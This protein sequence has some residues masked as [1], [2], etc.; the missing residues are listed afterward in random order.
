M[1]VKRSGDRSVIVILREEV[2]TKREFE[3]KTRENMLGESYWSIVEDKVKVVEG[4]KW[5]W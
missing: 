2:S 1:K 4:G 5:T 3:R